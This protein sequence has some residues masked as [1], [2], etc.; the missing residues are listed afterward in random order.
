LLDSLLQEIKWDH[1]D[2]HPAAAAEEVVVAEEDFHPVEV[3]VGEDFHLVAG[4]AV[5][6]EA[7]VE[8]DS[9]QVVVEDFHQV[10]VA[11]VAVV[12]RLE[13]VAEAEGDVEEWVQAARL[14]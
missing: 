11:E 7:V 8:E 1:P 13:G 10:V 2:F 14:W 3:A 9:H 12:G 4:V 6:E 5:V